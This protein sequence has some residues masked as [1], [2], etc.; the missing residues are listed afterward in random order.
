VLVDI[1]SS[2][3]LP[4][5]GVAKTDRTVHSASFCD[6]A[7]F[8]TKRRAGIPPHKRRSYACHLRRYNRLPKREVVVHQRNDR[9]H[10]REHATKNQDKKLSEN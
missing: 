1:S 10:Q 4:S 6:D 8:K 3:I 5:W 9:I 7:V 2:H